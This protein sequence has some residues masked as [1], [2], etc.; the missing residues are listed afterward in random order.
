MVV[1][2]RLSS[3]R[4]S[5]RLLYLIFVRV[6]G[7]LVLGARSD[8]SKRASD[9]YLMGSA[10]FTAVRCVPITLNARVEARLHKPRPSRFIPG[11]DPQSV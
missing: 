3:L 1:D 2:L 6:V 7:W 4:V 9:G 10:A 11:A 8:A 5:F